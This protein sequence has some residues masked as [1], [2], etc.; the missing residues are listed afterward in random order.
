MR[1]SRPV[2][3]AAPR[4]QRG[5]VLIIALMFLVLLTIIG[6]S[7]ISSTTV[8]ERMA[9]NSRDREAAFQAAESA[10]R[11]AEIDLETSIGGTGNRDTTVWAVGV[12]ATTV[13]VPCASSFTT[14]VCTNGPLTVPAGDYR[15]QIVT[16]STWDWTSTTKTVAYGTYTGA[17]TIPNVYRQ[18]RY[19][20]EHLPELIYGTMTTPTTKFFRISARGWGANQNTSVTLQSVYRIP[21]N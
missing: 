12:N 4:R 1:P 11:D 3:I 10:L 2:R 9:G 8:E 6:V 13:A 21:M 19:V 14:G 20:I 5:A 17:V 7:G 16:A 15:T 18:P